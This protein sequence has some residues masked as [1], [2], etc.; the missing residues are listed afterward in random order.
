[1]ES[2][3]PTLAQALNVALE[4]CR[5]QRKLIWMLTQN[6]NQEKLVKLSKGCYCCKAYDH[7]CL[8]DKEKFPGACYCCRGYDRPCLQDFLA[9]QTPMS[10]QDLEENSQPSPILPLVAPKEVNQHQMGIPAQV[11][12]VSD[13]DLSDWEIT[14]TEFHPRQRKRAGKPIGAG[15]HPISPPATGSVKKKHKCFN[16]GQPGHFAQQCRYP[17]RSP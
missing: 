11:D 3:S 1:M 8:Q 15:A 16:C 6:T 10:T 12:K 4:T 7:P 2:Q 5:E 17:C 9:K 14:C 13:M